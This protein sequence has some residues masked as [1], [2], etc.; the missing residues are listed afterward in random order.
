MKR[1]VMPK[2]VTYVKDEE[3]PVPADDTKTKRKYTR[4]GIDPKIESVIDDLIRVRALIEVSANLALSTKV[5][6]QTIKTASRMMTIINNA[7]NN[8]SSM[9][10]GEMKSMLERK[11]SEVQESYD[12]Y[13]TAISNERD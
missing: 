2:K 4:K 6:A 12:V 10:A 13:I 11:V 3:I 9:R 5:N 7:R 1:A 8:V